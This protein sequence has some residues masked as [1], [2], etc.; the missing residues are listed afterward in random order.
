MYI[1][2]APIDHDFR[3]PND[4][5]GREAGQHTGIDLIVISNGVY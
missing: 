4:G 1:S 2:Q 5:G 3:N